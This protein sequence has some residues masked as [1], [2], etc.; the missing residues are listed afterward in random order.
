MARSHWLN[1]PSQNSSKESGVKIK[2]PSDWKTFNETA[3]RLT[4]T[5]PL[6][7]R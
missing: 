3:L 4:V 6:K 2:K 5:S 7:K 1:K